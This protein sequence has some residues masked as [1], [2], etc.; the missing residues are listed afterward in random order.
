[1]SF[2]TSLIKPLAYISLP[3]LFVRSVAGSSPVGRYYVR[4]GVYL[5]CMTAVASWAAFVAAAMSI[6]GRRYDVNWVIARTFY[7]VAGRALDIEIEVEGE[8]HMETKP[9]VYLCNH[10]SLLDILFV[11]RMMPKRTSIMAKKSLQWT[12][13]G[14]FMV[15][16]G[17]IFVDRGNNV[18]AVRSLEAA[19]EFMKQARVGL[20]VY[21]EGTRHS[22]EVPDLLPFK[23][24]AFHLAIQAG[25]PVVPIV[26]ENYWRLYHKGAFEKGVVKIRVLPPV[27]TDGLTAKDVPALIE[28]V[29][30]QMLDNL[31]DISVK[32]DSDEPGK[33]TQNISSTQEA[34][35]PAPS[36][37]AVAS[38]GSS[39]PPPDLSSPFSEARSDSKDSL[40][41]SPTSSRRPSEPSENGTE[42]EEDEG[43]VLVGRPA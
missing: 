27:P 1:M 2:L 43:M 33:S 25:I 36:F 41:S 7:H 40:S 30:G 6:A 5:T 24:G 10:Q 29:R 3:V 21:P 15:M 37:P 28:R 9:A 18:R 23:K 38:V 31:R 39:L 42:T 32:V 20:W 17:A 11:A 35:E 26:T 19:G 16:S 14:P 12:P 13:L 34:T 4:L 8:E 22:A